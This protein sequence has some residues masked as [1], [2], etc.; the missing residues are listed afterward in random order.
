MQAI[1]HGRRSC[2]SMGSLGPVQIEGRNTSI[3]AVDSAYCVSE[4]GQLTII[5]EPIT[6]S[7][8]ARSAVLPLYTP[9]KCIKL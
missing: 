8:H 9:S 6:V 7:A 5:D 1:K 3:S 2:S 4:K